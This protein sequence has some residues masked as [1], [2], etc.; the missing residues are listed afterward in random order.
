MQI[1]G[2]H[3]NIYKAARLA[4]STEIH[5]S[6]VAY[7]QKILGD[8]ELLKS[9]GLKDSEIQ[10]ITGFSRATYY[11]RRK[12]L[13]L[14]GF[15][16]LQDLSKRPRIFRKSNLSPNVLDLTLKIRHENPNYGKGKITIILRRDY[17]VETSES[18]VG[19]ILKTLMNQGKIRK[20]R[21]ALKVHR[22]RK[23]TKHAK[24]WRYGMKGKTMGELIQIDHM[25]VHKNGVNVKHFR[26]GTRFPKRLWPKRIQPQ[27]APKEPN[28]W[29]KL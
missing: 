22:K 20:Y 26:L 25:S 3:R 9:K 16:G 2:L 19:R 15:K 11:R 28:F 21:A 7:R 24:H 13:E 14:L 17:G 23:F 1:L 4:L 6:Q 10:R 5:D 8:W 18:T 29:K 27:P 12:R